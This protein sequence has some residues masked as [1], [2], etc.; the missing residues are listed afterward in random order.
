MILKAKAQVQSLTEA[1]YAAAVKEGLLPEGVEVKTTT[2]LLMVRRNH[3]VDE[4]VVLTI[5]RGDQVFDAEV[6]LGSDRD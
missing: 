2:D 5:R 1:A 4:T 3:G 6:V